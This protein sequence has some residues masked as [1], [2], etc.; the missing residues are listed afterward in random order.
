M[1][2]YLYHPQY[3]L[4]NAGLGALHLP[5]IDWLGDPRWAMPAIIL[6]SVWHGVGYPLVIFLAG[7]QGVPEELYDAAH[8]D[9]AGGWQ[10][11]RHITVPLLSPT[12]FFV[13]VTAIINSFQ[14]FAE[15]YVMTQG[16][17]ANSTARW[18]FCPTT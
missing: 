6:M 5:A 16:G 15:T 8:I 7:L 12:T 2:R 14:V 9:G 4:V 1:W 11:F 13:I 17:P 10:R 3:G 18:N